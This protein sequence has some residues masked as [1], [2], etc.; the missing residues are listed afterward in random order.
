MI[1]KMADEFNAHELDLSRW[2]TLQALP[3]QIRP[4]S[5][6]VNA[7]EKSLAVS[8]HPGDRGLRCNPDVP[9]QRAEIRLHR[10]W[11]PIY[12]E[13]FWHSFIFKIS[14][15]IDETSDTRTVIGQWKSPGDDSPV[16]AQRFNNGVF[17]ITAQDG[18]TRHLIAS[19]RHDADNIR[20]LHVL[21]RF[22]PDLTT[23]SLASAS[24]PLHEFNYLSQSADYQGKSNLQIGGLPGH[25]LPSPH[26]R[27]VHMMYRI[28][29]GRTDNTCGPTQKGEIDIY[30]NGE[31]IASAQGNLG[32]PQTDPTLDPYMFF[33]FGVYRDVAPGTMTFHMERW[34]SGPTMK[35][36]YTED[37]KNL[38]A[39]L[40]DQRF[41]EAVL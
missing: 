12:G 25:V 3:H 18:E 16:L 4:S 14:G 35:S 34:R 26:N 23:Q 22:S 7:R 27:W 24:P 41:A 31:F 19:S 38:V 17:Y 10:D 32:V 36:V 30:T 33:K 20:L 1:N 2:M 37:D 9:G 15:D 21:N 6:G 5:D 11:R 40:K 13:E 8:V 29:M 39:R 28:K